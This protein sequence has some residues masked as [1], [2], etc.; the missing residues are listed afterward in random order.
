VFSQTKEILLRSALEDIDRKNYNSA[1]VKIDQCLD[2]DSRYAYA[3]FHRG[4]CYLMLK[5]PG[6]A[7]VDFNR[8]LLLD[9]TLSE[10]Y[11]NRALA[12]QALKNY[13]FSEGDFITYLKFNPRDEKA[14]LN[15]A[16]L[17]EEME[18]YITAVNDYGNCL[19]IK[20]RSAEV[21]KYRALA[22]A[23]IDSV[24]KAIADYNACY[25]L[26]P[27]DSSLWLLKGNVYYDALM[28]KEAI[29]QYNLALLNGGSTEALVNRA[30]AYTASGQ[31]EN[32]IMDYQQLSL[33]DKRN[34]DYYFNTGFCFLQ[35]NQPD[36]AIASF[37]KAIDNDYENLGQL[38]TFRGVAY[39][40]LQMKTEA[41]A[42][43]Q[44]AYSMGY[45]EAA[46]Y[47]NNYCQ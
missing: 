40:N 7:V 9:S 2:M 38:L 12:H 33:K 6:V 23:E 37:A 36:N 16:F 19:K 26:N 17:H 8:T 20:P 29:E 14:W 1:I 44:K 46:K 45:K 39:N 21:L 10:T 47:Q 5:K 42:D 24:Q 30:D 13:T 34:P 27:S 3:Y 28:Y 25:S 15:L 32:A 31:F 11:F 22:Y 18:D 35:L 43:W 41:C 4:F